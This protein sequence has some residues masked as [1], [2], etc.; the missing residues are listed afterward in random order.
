M[1]D[2][3]LRGVI[4]QKFY[5]LR[6]SQNLIELQDLAHVGTEDW[7]RTANICVQLE[8]H[9]LILWKPLDSMTGT[10]AGTGKISA[11]GVDVIEGHA[12]API[13]ISFHHSPIITGSSNVQVGNSNVLN[14]ATIDIEKINAAIDHSNASDAEKQEA[15]SLWS[16][17]INNPTFAAVLGAVMTMS[18]GPAH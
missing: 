17:L 1:T 2:N 18:G 14:Q 10:V 7:Q 11:F 12:R 15:K 6:H 5:D 16:R 8:Q 4:L 13:S 3:E 9:G